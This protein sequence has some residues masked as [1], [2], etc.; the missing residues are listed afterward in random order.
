MQKFNEII[1]FFKWQMSA[2]HRILARAP[3]GNVVSRAISSVRR[4]RLYS[5][6]QVCFMR[7]LLFGA[8][9]MVGQGVLRECLQARDVEFIQ[10]VGRTRIPQRARNLREVILPDLFDIAAIEDE[11]RNFDACFFCLG[12]PSAGKS[13]PTYARMTFDLTLGVAQTLV[14]LNSQMTFVYVSGAGTYSTER[15]RW[16]WARVKGRTENALLQ[17][18]F[19]AVYLL[20]PGIIQPLYGARSKVTSYRIIYRLATPLFPLLRSAFP[21]WILTTETVGLAMLGVAR[22]GAAK[23]ILEA[24]DISE[25][26]AAGR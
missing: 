24:S 17:L 20:R 7:I 23:S 14:R 10:A 11:L 3:C 9:G 5:I 16:M 22:R 8:T 26:A 6:D 25:I 12:V 13:E 21:N 19:K 1:G 2:G 18:P 4:G 15:G